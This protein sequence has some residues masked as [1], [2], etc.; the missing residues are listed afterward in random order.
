[1]TFSK[2]KKNTNIKEFENRE[3]TRK[4]IT[5]TEFYELG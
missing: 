3:K 4:V 1:M 2:K 5:K